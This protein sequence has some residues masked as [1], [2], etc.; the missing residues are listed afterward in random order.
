MIKKLN[1]RKPYS[2]PMFLLLAQSIIPY[3]EI[4]EYNFALRGSFITKIG[5]ECITQGK[6]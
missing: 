3:K 6:V 4:I 2:V 1:F 5:Q